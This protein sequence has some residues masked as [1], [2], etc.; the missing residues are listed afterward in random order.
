M[1][2]NEPMPVKVSSLLSNPSLKLISLSTMHQFTP[3]SAAAGQPSSVAAREIVK[4]SLPGFNKVSNL[5]TFKLG[6]TYLSLQ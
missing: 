6:Q 3:P 1:S 5:S 2:V 4:V